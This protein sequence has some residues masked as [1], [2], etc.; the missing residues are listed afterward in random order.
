M[1]LMLALVLVTTGLF[2]VGAR[3]QNLYQFVFRG[4]SYQTNAAGNFVTKPINERTLLTAWARAAGR[5]NV[6]G[7]APVYHVGGNELGDTIEVINTTNGVAVGTLL[8]LYFGESFGR[9]AVKNANDTQEK[10]LDYIYTD[11]NSHSIGAA[12]V[13]KRISANTNGTSRTSASGQMT[14]EVLPGGLLPA[15]I[16]NGNFLT[17]KAFNF[18]SGR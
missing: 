2:P 9:L 18:G 3:G 10:R 5:P 16:V 11:Q 6:R 17:G 12:T 14:W 7:L 4:V 13:N 1:K 8:G 15:G